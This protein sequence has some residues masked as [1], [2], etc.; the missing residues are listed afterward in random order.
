[1]RVA[2]AKGLHLALPLYLVWWVKF[3]QP[4]WTTEQGM[5]NY[6]GTIDTERAIQ[7]FAIRRPD[8]YQ[9]VHIDI[10]DSNMRAHDADTT[11]NRSNSSRSNHAHHNNN[12]SAVND[13]T[14]VRAPLPVD[15]NDSA[16][17]SSHVQAVHA[18][19]PTRVD[20]S[21]ALSP[22][23]HAPAPQRN[24]LLHLSRL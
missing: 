3:D 17:N 24:P 18:S 9:Q 23:T 8:I 16:N 11:H 14:R 15:I 10:D 5:R 2:P 1:M 22:I 19:P 13:S 6:V 4:E 21:L 20:T 12:P 7:S